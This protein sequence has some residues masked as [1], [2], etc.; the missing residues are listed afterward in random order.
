VGVPVNN[1]TRTVL[2]TLESTITKN[3]TGLGNG[4]PPGVMTNIRDYE[5]L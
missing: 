3:C 4:Q 2:M 5:K 1:N